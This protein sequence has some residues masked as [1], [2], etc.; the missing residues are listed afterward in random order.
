M[1]DCLI[2]VTTL[3]WA[4]SKILGVSWDGLNS[5]VLYLSM[6]HHSDT[7]T[8]SGAEVI[9][10]GSADP[11]FNPTFDPD[12]ALD[13][14]MSELLLEDLQSASSRSPRKQGAASPAHEQRGSSLF[15]IAALEHP[16]DALLPDPSLVLDTRVSAQPDP[17]PEG[18]KRT[19]GKKAKKEK[20]VMDATTEMSD[21]ELKVLLIFVVM[22]NF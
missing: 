19:S 9:A 1:T 8:R 18:S 6:I 2:L 4:V 14:G 5:M 17:M 20:L 16:D 12:L 3:D 7:V 13:I 11:T 15:V 22:Y 21:D 10:P